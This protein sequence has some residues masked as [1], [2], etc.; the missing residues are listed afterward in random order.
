MRLPELGLLS[1]GTKIQRDLQF[2]NPILIEEDEA[3]K[4]ECGL[5]LVGLGCEVLL[6]L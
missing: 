6:Q 3:K 2:M 4:G 5:D 1:R